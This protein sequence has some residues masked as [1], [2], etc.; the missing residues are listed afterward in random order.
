MASLGNGNEDGVGLGTFWGHAAAGDLALEDAFANG[1]LAVVI[2][3]GAAGQHREGQDAAAQAL[4]GRDDSSEDGIG[5][6][7]VVGGSF[8]GKSPKPQVDSANAPAGLIGPNVE[9]LAD[10]P[11][12]FFRDGRQDGGDPDG[13]KFR[14]WRCR[15]A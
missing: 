11:K 4:D 14:R 7:V 9:A 8:I 1:V 10:I 5:C 3:A 6:S 2:M 13:W 15:A 12:D